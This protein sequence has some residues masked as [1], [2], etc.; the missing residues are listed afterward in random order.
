MDEFVV[1]H[2]ANLAM[3][4]DADSAFL[5]EQGLPRDA[6]PFLS[7][8]AY[9][10][11]EIRERLDTFAV[12]KDYF[13]IGHNGSGD[14]VAIDTNRGEVVYFN[15]DANNLRVFIN[16]TLPLF[17]ECL[18]I[19]QEHLRSG[20]MHSCLSDIEAVD[21][22]AAKTGSMWHDAVLAEIANG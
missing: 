13:P 12:S 20:M 5:L 1:F 14:I 18:C 2:I 10:P 4:D 15:H 22:K 9:T 17:A 7:F 11:E 19:F 8:A 6:S 21:A 16:S 3:L